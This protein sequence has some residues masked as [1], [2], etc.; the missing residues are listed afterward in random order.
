MK[1]I[2]LTCKDS[3]KWAHDC[4]DCGHY[5]KCDFFNKAERKKEAKK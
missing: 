1:R 4:K 2:T 5:E 3:G